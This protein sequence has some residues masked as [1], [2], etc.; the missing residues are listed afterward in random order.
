MLA[1]AWVNVLRWRTLYNK[2]NDQPEGHEALL[3]SVAGCD[4]ND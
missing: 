3:P 2:C 1:E 4:E